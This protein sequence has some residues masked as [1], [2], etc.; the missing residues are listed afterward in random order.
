[1]IIV[2]PPPKPEKRLGAFLTVSQFTFFTAPNTVTPILG[3]YSN[4]GLINFTGTNTGIFTYTGS[5]NVEAVINCSF[6]L[7]GPP[8]NR[9]YSFYVSKNG[10]IEQNSRQARKVDNQGDVGSVSLTKNIQLSTGD[11]IQLFCENNNDTAP[12]EVVFLYISIT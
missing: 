2:Q 10:T 12:L 5:E 4:D 9:R 11:T 3:T 7:L 6:T 1:M 8:N